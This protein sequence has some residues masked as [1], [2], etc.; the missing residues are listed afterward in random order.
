MNYYEIY[1]AETGKLIA[2]G[3]A[4]ECRKQLGC[5]SLDS[6]YA[7]ANRSLCGINKKYHVIKKK[8]GETDYPVLGVT[9]PIH[10]NQ[11]R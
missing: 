2:K 1:S 10:K 11:R 6:F 9:D 5:S 4:R 8:G 7:L 3:T